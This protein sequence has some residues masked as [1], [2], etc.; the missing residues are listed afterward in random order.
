M[1]GLATLDASHRNEAYDGVD[2]AVTDIMGSD[3]PSRAV[4]ARQ[5]TLRNPI[6]C[7][8]VGLH[9]GRQVTLSLQP[10]AVD[11]GIVFRRVDLGAA[12]AGIEIPA[13]FDRVVD[14]R[15]CTVVASR[16]D[17]RLRVGTIEHLT[18]ALAGCGIDNARIEI[19]GPEIPALDGSAA[20][21]MFLI[22]CAGRAEQAAPRRVIEVIKPV[23]VEEGLA[24]A[25]FHPSPA[26]CLSLNL[27]I[28]FPARVIGRQSYG[29]ILTR[30]AFRRE[31]ARCRTFT[32]LDEIEALREAGLA[33][34]GSLDNAV[35]V[36]DETVL[37]PAGL[38]CG[39]EFVRHKM[40]DAVGDLSLG[41]HPIR[42]A[43]VGH[44]SG[45]GLNNRLLR[46][47]LGDP[48]TWR[49]SGHGLSGESGTGESRTGESRTGPN[50]LAA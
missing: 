15:F 12:A 33:R 39:D 22:D 40:L 23:R 34:G 48:G 36:D 37:N 2:G 4:A 29:M 16:T 13:R 27:S 5:P 14:T 38:R 11:T 49:I 1:D 8:G 19:D 43:F 3:S 24:F 47:L 6:S 35:V 50:I 9:S 42:G 44:R 30:Q 31:L 25:E 41:G 21:F 10:A 46:A 17:A 28:D 26:A 45:H 20:P 32:M 18:A 7:S